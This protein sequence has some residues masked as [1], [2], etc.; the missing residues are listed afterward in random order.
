MKIC[1]ICLLFLVLTWGQNPARTVP[2]LNFYTIVRS[3][4]SFTAFSCRVGCNR[5]VMPL[6]SI[7]CI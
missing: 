6:C 7:V 4:S 2:V 1:E 5:I 3:Q